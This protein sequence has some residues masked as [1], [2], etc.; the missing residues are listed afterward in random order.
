M[1]DGRSMAGRFVATVAELDERRLQQR[2]DGVAVSNIDA[3]RERVPARF[4]GEVRSQQRSGAD[5]RPVLKVTVSDGTGEAVAIFTGRTRIRGLEAGRAVLFEGVGRRDRGRLT[6]L[7]P[8]YT[9]L[10]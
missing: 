2:F 6:V 4:G 7:N 3:V 5:G 10:P 9:V 1:T 8:A